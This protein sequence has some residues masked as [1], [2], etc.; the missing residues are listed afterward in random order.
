MIA[1]NMPFKTWGR[2]E[3]AGGRTAS[4]V[5][6][7]YF[8]YEQKYGWRPY[9]CIAS[10]VPMPAPRWKIYYGSDGAARLMMV[11][12]IFIRKPIR[13]RFCKQPHKLLLALPRRMTCAL[14]PIPTRPLGVLSASCPKCNSGMGPC[15]HSLEMNLAH[16][17]NQ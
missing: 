9:A 5:G 15:Y 14:P 1:R 16:E 13:G 12:G 2:I 10:P 17:N 11:Q 7:V 3:W 8:Q 6:T 4:F